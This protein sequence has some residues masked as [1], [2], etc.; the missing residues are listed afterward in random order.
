MR[1]LLRPT[2]GK[3]AGLCTAGVLVALI[4]V[5]GGK[6]FSPGELN[7]EGRGGKRG[8]V[9]SH[10]DVGGNCGAC[11]AAPWSAETM[12]TRCLDCHDDVR[13]Q[14][15]AHQPLHGR[16]SEGM[17]CR[18][19]HTEHNGPHGALTSL[20]RFD[21]EATAFPLTGK[22]RAL[23]CQ[24]C[25]RDNVFQG[26]P[27]SCVSCHAEPEVHKGR[28]GVGC[29]ECHSTSTWSGATFKHTFPLDHGRRGR[30]SECA[31]CHT[32]PDD[33]RTYTCYGCHAHEPARVERKHKGI[34]NLQNCVR[35]HPTG[36]ED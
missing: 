29:R 34:V 27:Q 11:H 28:F 26:T 5:S 25:H 2:A 21:H 36:R 30:A 15:D 14:I 3:V 23:D 18:C 6:M 1:R 16:L 10:A 9:G 13:R 33:Y 22:H 4:A 7:A 35:C 12:A 17:Q 20:A 19:C 31:T 8:G 32:E 24:S